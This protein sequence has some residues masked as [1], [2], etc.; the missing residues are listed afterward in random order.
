MVPSRTAERALFKRLE[1]VE[2]EYHQAEDFGR[3]AAKDS[4]IACMEFLRARGL[5]GQAMKALLDLVAA[6]EDVERG[7]LPE[8]F[9]P[10]AGTIAGASGKRKWSNSS[11]GQQIKVY[12][13]ACMSALM[14]RGMPKKQAM[15]KVARS[16][17]HWPRHSS[18]IIN[19][20][21]VANWRDEL[22]QAPSKDSGRLQ[23]EAH[24]EHF[25]G[26]PR[27]R[28][29]LDDILEHGPLLTGGKR[30]PKT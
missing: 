8:L 29:W 6:L 25:I 23:Y 15:A 27:G 1:D 10:K 17:R 28:R 11:A 20:N 2:L 18:G 3:K 12:A 22:M 24:M 14:K 9:S 4:L 5:S 30:K 26:K 7:N 13:A 21:T 19:A 16:A